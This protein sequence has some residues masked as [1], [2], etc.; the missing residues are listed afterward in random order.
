MP[1]G[2]MPIEPVSIAAS[3]DRMSPNMLPVTTTSKAFGR[4][5]QLHRR[6]VDVHVLERHVGVLRM[7]LGDHV[8]PE[9][10]GLQ[11]VGL[12]DAGHLLACC[13]CA[14]PGRRRA[15]C[16]RSRAAVAHGVEGFFGARE[17]AVDRGA[18]AAR[19]AEVDVAGELADD[20][21]VQP[22][23]QFGLQADA[24]RELLVA[25]RRA[26]VGEQAQVLAQPRMACSGRSGARACRTSS[27]PRRR[28]ARRRRPWPGSASLRAA[29]GR[30]AS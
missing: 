26:E 6:V 4:L 13:A 7:H 10:E 12:V 20:Q 15:R 27:R 25:D 30:A 18:A 11:H 5:D 1:T 28:T 19:L 3:S 14:P 22:R 24:V 16:A 2:S 8:L 23:H 9:L 21:D 17:V 29:G